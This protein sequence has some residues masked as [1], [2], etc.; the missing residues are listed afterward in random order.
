MKSMLLIIALLAIASCTTIPMRQKERSP[1]E[2][3]MFI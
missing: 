1:L 2:A 3:K